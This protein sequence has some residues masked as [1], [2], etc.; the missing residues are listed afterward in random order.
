MEDR[1]QIVGQ[2]LVVKVPEELDHHNCN[3]MKDEIDV[4][5]G[6]EAIDRIVFD[7]AD[8]SFMDS[9]GIGVIMGRYKKMQFV[10]G[11]VCAVGVGDRVYKILVLSGIS[12][13]IQIF[14]KK[15]EQLC[16]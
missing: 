7:F 3:E 5:I 2:D 4:L 16:Q 12:K 1:M 15:E 13:F 6:E 8:T 9:S 11:E 10:G 14:K